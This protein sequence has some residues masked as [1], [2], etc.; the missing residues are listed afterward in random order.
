MGERQGSR[1]RVKRY[2]QWW[3]VAAVGVVV[4]LSAG[5]IA[6]VIISDDSVTVRHSTASSTTTSRR[7]VPPSSALPSSAHC[8]R[9]QRFNAPAPSGSDDTAALVRFFALH[10]AGC[11]AFPDHATYELDGELTI[12]G[13][14]D[15]EIRGNGATLAA[16]TQGDRNRQHV[17]LDKSSRVTI[18]NLGVRGANQ[19]H[20]RSYLP[21]IFQHGFEVFSSTDITLTNLRVDEVYGD[22]IYI[23][24]KGTAN[25]VVKGGSF[26][27]TGRQGV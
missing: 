18:D 11:V 5:A 26:S 2:R 17:V 4:L 1:R 6:A 25:V 10:P 27:Y 19:R 24:G 3:I 21:L 23:G 14:S 20:L 15:L 7:N 9:D 13:A 8:A 22:A 16:T 12:S